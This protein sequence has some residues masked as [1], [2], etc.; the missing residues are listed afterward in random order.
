MVNKIIVRSCR[1]DGTIFY[2]LHLP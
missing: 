1:H 2:P